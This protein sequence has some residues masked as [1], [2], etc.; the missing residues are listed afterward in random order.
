[1]KVVFLA[2]LVIL[3]PSAA[4]GAGSSKLCYSVKE[5]LFA[6]GK[7]LGH[8]NASV[9]MTSDEPALV[10]FFVTMPDSPQ[11]LGAEQLVSNRIAPNSH[12]FRFLDGW[13]NEGKGTLVI[14]GRQADLI[15]EV[16]NVK[17]GGSNILRNYGKFKLSLSHC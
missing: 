15:L 2:L 9:S 11:I 17:S 10:S 12:E 6:N 3:I 8:I 16:E 5:E 13:G 14:S 1:M 4:W 7:P